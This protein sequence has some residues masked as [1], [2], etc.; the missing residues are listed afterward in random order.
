MA[1]NRVLT[2]R[3]LAEASVQA[4]ALRDGIAAIRAEQHVSAH[5]PVEVQRAAEEAA[6]A[7]RLPDRDLTDLPFVTIDPASSRD[8]DQAL[9]LRRSGRGYVLSY[10]IADVAAFVPPGGPVDREAHRRG[11]SFYGADSK[12]PLHPTVLS[13]GAASLLP[14]QVV[15]ALVWTVAMDADGDRTSTRVERAMVRSRA[16]LDYEGVQRA[17]DAGTAEEPLAL[18]RELGEKRIALEIARGGMTLPMPEQEI[19]IEGDEWRLEFRSQLP[20]E[21][22]NAQMSLVCGIGAAELM[23]EGRVGLLRTLP[24]SDPRDVTRLRRTAHAL[25]VD[26]PR[27]QSA[28]DFVRRLDPGVPAEAALAVASSRLL[29][30]SGYAAFDGE[31]PERTEHAALASAYTHVTAP[32]RRLVDRYTGEVALSLC[33]GVPVPDWV[34]EALGGLPETMRDSTRR[35]NAYEK[36][37]VD[38]VETGIL[39]HRVGE[40]F[41]ATVVEVAEKD[42]RRGEVIVAE[43]AVE[44]EVTGPDSLPLGAGV[45]VRLVAADPASR[46]VVFELV[47]P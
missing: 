33:A 42:P 44:A 25:N 10:A 4:R 18:L 14:G 31:L 26:W 2:L 1:S 13:E 20:V 37:M 34:R 47:S 28:P 41:A 19:V 46:R 5:F 24:P 32:L 40:E 7:P 21:L 11:Q 16:K 15:P 36:A 29:R 6:A 38:L 39:R 8:L 35:A 22:W 27:A 23:L 3:P 43:P 30:G 17:L 12:I 45:T 9:H